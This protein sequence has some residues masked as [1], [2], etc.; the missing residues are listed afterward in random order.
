MITDRIRRYESKYLISEETAQI[1]RDS[2]QGICS[3]DEHIDADGRYIVNNLYFDTHDLRFF[4]DTKFKRGA[5]FK[6]RVRY[7]G[8][9]PDRYLWLE[10]KHKNNNVTWKI[11]RRVE[12]RQWP[13]LIEDCGTFPEQDRIGN[14]VDS[15]EDAVLRF[16][17]RPILHVRYIREPYVSDLDE[18]ARVTFDR[19]LTFRPA[20]DSLDLNTPDDMIYYDDPETTKCPSTHSW[21]VLE[22][23]TETHVPLWV[24]H[25]IRRFDLSQ[26][27]FSKYCYAVD[28][29]LLAANCHDRE[30]AL[31]SRSL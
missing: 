10:L 2:L 21:V 19:C 17:A 12:C 8:M 18:Y 1:I 5:R 23:K 29:S 27:G 13:R 25:L 11:R 24:T 15:F 22:I 31:I 26:R 20:C 9:S 14:I 28:N 4:Y 6:P 7:Y 3:P 16:H 30:S